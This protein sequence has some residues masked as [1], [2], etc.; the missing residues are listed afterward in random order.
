MRI[1]GQRRA[2]D[3][4]IFTQKED[5]AAVGD[6]FGL[7][8]GVIGIGDVLGHVLR[9]CGMSESFIE[10]TRRKTGNVI[11]IRKRGSSQDYFG[12]R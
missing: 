11:G 5:R 12:L 10:Y 4:V 2:L 9:R 1:A 6:F 7:D 8:S 3:A